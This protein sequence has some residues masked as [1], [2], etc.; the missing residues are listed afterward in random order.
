MNTDIFIKKSIELYKELNKNQ[1]YYNSHHYYN[2]LITADPLYISPDTYKV[3][4]SKGKDIWKW[5]DEQHVFLREAFTSNNLNWFKQLLSKIFDKKSYDYLK[6]IAERPLKIS[7]ILRADLSSFPFNCHEAQL[8]WGIAGHLH[9]IDSLFNKVIPTTKNS[10]I[11]NQDLAVTIQE[12]VH[13]YC[14][15]DNEI[16][17]FLTSKKYFF[18]TKSFVDLIKRTEMVLVKD[19][20]N[21]ALEIKNNELIHKQSGKKV[22]LIFRRQLTLETLAKHTLGQKIIELYL[23]GKIK[24][25]P[26]LNL[27]TDNKLGMP[28]VFDARSRDYFSNSSRE[29]FLKTAFFSKDFSSFNSVFQTKY[30]NFKDFLEKTTA[31]Q[32]KYVFKY[33]GSKLSMCYGGG[34]VYRFDRSAK[35]T[36]R[37]VEAGLQKS[38]ADNEWI[39]QE[40]DSNRFEFRYLEGDYDN[41]N[42]CHIEKATNLPARIM[43]M[44]S[45]IDGKINLTHCLANFVTD[46]W[47]A[48]LKNSNSKKGKGAIVT[49]IRVK[50]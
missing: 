46:H 17:I 8:R 48:R 9:F 23:D 26:D 36:K 15:Q 7:Q 27:I 20:F 32:R 14:K 10:K 43:I 22:K 35:L 11:I 49:S 19:F 44:Y 34:E 3:L 18:E 1:I 29:L 41:P 25:E 33:G 6:K 21:N 13:Q 37:I 30:D 2:K 38:K 40:M 47:K 24:F 12:I 28:I 16:C 31:S 45:N 42:T 39:I 5:I 50:E 4:L